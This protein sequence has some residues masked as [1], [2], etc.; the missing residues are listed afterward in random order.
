MFPIRIFRVRIFRAVVLALAVAAGGAA[1]E[2]QKPSASALATAK[3]LITV[4]GG[5][6]IYEPIVPGVIEQARRIL[7]QTNPML[8]KPMN[9]VAASLR[10]E[11]ASRG[12]ELV[13]EAAKLYAL[14]FS[15]QELKEV[16]AFYKTPLG[17]KIV[18]QEPAI[19]DESLRSA[20]T[21]ADRLSEEIIGKFRA[22]MKKKGHEI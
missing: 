22:E 4:K 20:K 3:E 10:A 13:N 19:L 7:L 15:E 5:T 8:S 14:R 21:W 18:T 11:Y 6:A 9:E 1:A 2:A 12:E 17:R 16:L